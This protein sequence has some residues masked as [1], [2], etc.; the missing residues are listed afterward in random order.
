MLQ[1]I[2]EQATTSIT[3]APVV[4]NATFKETM[5]MAIG[6]KDTGS[7]HNFAEGF[8]SQPEYPTTRLDFI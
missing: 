5:C 7:A 6:F 2:V 1:R 3:T 4:F 8:G